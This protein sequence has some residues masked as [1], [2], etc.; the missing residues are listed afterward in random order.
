MS[1]TRSASLPQRERAQRARESRADDGDIRVNRQ[2]HTAN[3]SWHCGQG[4]CGST[5]CSRFIACSRSATGVQ[6]VPASGESI[7]IPE[8]GEDARAAAGRTRLSER[9]APLDVRQPRLAKPSLACE[10]L[11]RAVS[12]ARRDERDRRRTGGERHVDGAQKPVVLFGVW[13]KRRRDQQKHTQRNTKRLEFVRRE[14]ESLDRHPLVQALERV[15]VRS[16]ES[17]RDLERRP[18]LVRLSI[19]LEGSEKSGGPGANQ[20]R[21]RFDDDVGETG[22]AGGDVVVVGIGNRSRIEE[23]AG[24]VQLH[25]GDGIVRVVQR[26]ARGGDLRG[27][28]PARRVAFGRV[29]P[30]IAHHAA[31]GTLAAGEEDRGHAGDGSVR[32]TLVLDEQSLARQGSCCCRAGRRSRT[33]RSRAAA[34]AG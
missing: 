26:P 8:I 32:G 2:R 3:C 23:A 29:L 1:A 19:G 15:R 34:P 5:R 9:D 10:R 30:E 31:P 12:S 33:K 24:V 21:M 20:R 25:P 4:G 13:H 17:H 18:S 22:E 16:L 28:G 11:E 14:P 27:D 7:Q 6:A